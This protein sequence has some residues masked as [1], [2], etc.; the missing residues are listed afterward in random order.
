MLFN[1]DRG[2]DG[3][4]GES[5]INPA[6]ARFSSAEVAVTD[7]GTPTPTPTPTVSPTTPPPAGRSC[8]ARLAIVGSWTGGFQGEVTVTAGSGG[9]SGWTA[10]WTLASGQRVT[11]SWGA[12]VSASGSTV[13]A[14]N[15][16]WNGTLAA[17]S[18]TTFGFLAEG[19]G[20]APTLTCAAT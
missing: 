13:T 1:S 9:T 6:Y 10:T 4:A 7:G 2:C 20:T 18:S 17:G 8:S 5:D 16:G 11:Q 19:A 3:R 15:A 12:T 14:S